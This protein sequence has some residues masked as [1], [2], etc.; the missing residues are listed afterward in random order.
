MADHHSLFK[1]AVIAVAV[2]FIVYGAVAT[3]D[4]RVLFGTAFIAPVEAVPLSDSL[5]MSQF[6]VS[7]SVSF[8]SVRRRSGNT[9]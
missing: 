8:A 1:A 9:T 5:R 4:R 3:A 6:L 7:F 2:A